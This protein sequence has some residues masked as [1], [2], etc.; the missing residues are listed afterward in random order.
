[1]GSKGISVDPIPLGES[2]DKRQS[3]PARGENIV[4]MAM[5]K[6][7]ARPKEQFVLE[8]YALVTDKNLDVMEYGGPLKLIPLE[9]SIQDE[10]NWSYR[11]RVFNDYFSG[12]TVEEA[13]CMILRGLD[14]ITVEGKNALAGLDVLRCRDFIS[15]HM[16]KLHKYLHYRMINLQSIEELARRWYPNVKPYN[17]M[18]PY[19]TVKRIHEDIRF[20]KYYRDKIFLKAKEENEV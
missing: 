20:L 3:I 14:G 15:R 9:G 5:E 8:M 12:D 6:V 4:W 1:M 7:W 2:E 16:P 17:G 18:P 11:M 19:G 13:E 10:L